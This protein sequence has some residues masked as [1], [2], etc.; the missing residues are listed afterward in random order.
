MT[1]LIL[2]KVLRQ[3]HNEDILSFLFFEVLE[4]LIS[5]YCSKPLYIHTMIYK[6]ER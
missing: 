6:Y 2:N 1:E 5:R 3:N 4:N